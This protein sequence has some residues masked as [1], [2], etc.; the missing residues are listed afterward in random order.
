MVLDWFYYNG[1]FYRTCIPT[2]KKIKNDP[3]F[4]LKLPFTVTT[5]GAI[6]YLILALGHG[7]ITAAYHSVY[8]VR[9]LDWVLTTPILLVALLLV[10][11]LNQLILEKRVK[12]IS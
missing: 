4:N 9:Y 3:H 8:Y 7:S 10:L 6:S 11:Y 12:T 2:W 1:N 5:I